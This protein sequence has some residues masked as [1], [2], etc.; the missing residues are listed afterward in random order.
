[1]RPARIFRVTRTM[2]IQCIV[3]LS[4]LPIESEQSR[5]MTATVYKQMHKFD[6]H[7]Q[8]ENRLKNQK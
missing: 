8:T 3:L 1:M 5:G 7:R 2:F 6:A 4:K